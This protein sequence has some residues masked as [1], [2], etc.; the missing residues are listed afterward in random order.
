MKLN[1]RQ[2][3]LLAAIILFAGA[4]WL[5]LNAGKLLVR[6]DQLAPAD[7]IVVLMGSGPDRVLEAVDLYKAGYCNKILMVENRRP[8]YELLESRNVSIPE[9]TDLNKSVGIQLGV[10]EKAFIILPGGA[11][12]TQEEAEHIR[13]YLKANPK[14]DSI[15]VVS[16]RSHTARAARIF[17]RTLN[18]NNHNHI[19]I[20]ARPSRYDTFNARAWWKSREDTE[21]VVYEYI[22]LVV[23]YTIDR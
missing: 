11:Q 14:M 19:T 21:Q 4:L 10:P 12:S 8:G 3:S 2:I 15:I 7:L 9:D 23:F 18:R 17:Q 13:G 22:K 20:L 6:E 1:K 5:F 16:S